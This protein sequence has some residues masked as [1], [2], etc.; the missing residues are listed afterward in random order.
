MYHGKFEQKKAP[1][2]RNARWARN[3]MTT[4][5]LSTLLVL[6]LGIG[7]TLALLVDSDGPIKNSFTP[8]QVSC[9]VTE[10]FNGGVKKDVNVV[11]DSNITAY[12]RVKLVTY[13]VNDD[14]Q[15]IGGTAT[16][17]NFTLGA[18]WFEQDGYYYYSYPVVAGA[19][20]TANLIDNDA[21]E[22]IDYKDADGGKQVIEVMAEAIQSVPTDVVTTNW[23]VT[24]GADGNLT[25]RTQTTGGTE[26]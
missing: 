25:E 7:G 23:K 20:P 21:I 1:T 17:P 8:A 9:H 22:L 16:I 13:R 12:I 19:S 3:R 6:T 14:G 10:S 15:H 18:D 24:V 11:N 2:K 4:L 26:G 5:V